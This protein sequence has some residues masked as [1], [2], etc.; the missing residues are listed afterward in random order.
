MEQRARLS[1]QI[2]SNGGAYECDLI[3]GVVTAL[4]ANRPEGKKHEAARKWN[5]PVVSPEWLNESVER[6]MALE[7]EPFDPL[8]PL[9][10]QGRVARRHPASEAPT[11]GKRQRQ[12]GPADALPSSGKRKLRRTVSSKLES[13]Q[14]NIWAEIADA[15]A[16]RPASEPPC[17]TEDPRPSTTAQPEPNAESFYERSNSLQV[18]DDQ[19]S[20]LGS[21]VLKASGAQGK[22]P[23]LFY[24]INIG[25]HGFDGKKVRFGSLT[26]VETS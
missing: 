19:D 25:I 13:Q 15:A 2:T 24:G 7:M 3:K 14:E 8:L 21:N 26:F 12:D 16:T 5:I 10:E 9:E 23:G 20:G 22:P 4:I 18:L 1:T 17:E 11:T 6:G